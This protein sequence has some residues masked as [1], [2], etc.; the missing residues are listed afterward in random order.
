MSLDREAMRKD[1]ET[2]DVEAG[3]RAV[4]R[5]RTEHVLRQVL[6]NSGS[7]STRTAEELRA[8]G[9]VLQAHKEAHARSRGWGLEAALVAAVAI[10]VAFLHF[11]EKSSIEI[12]LRAAASDV[13]FVSKQD[14]S[15]ADGAVPINA[16]SI[17]GITSARLPPDIGSRVLRASS[18][19]ITLSVVSGTGSRLAVDPLPLKD[20]TV[21]WLTSSPPSG[22]T[23]RVIDTFAVSVSAT[24]SG[25]ILISGGQN[26]TLALRSP[27]AL[28]VSAESQ[29]SLLVNDSSLNLSRGAVP[30]ERLSFNA[31]D[32]F[33]A[34]STGRRVVAS[35]L[36]SGALRTGVLSDTSAIDLTAGLSFARSRGHLTVLK[37]DNGSIHLRFIG[38]VWNMK[39]AI[40]R[41]LMPSRLEWIRLYEQ[42]HL[43]AGTVISIMAALLLIV[44][45]LG[46]RDT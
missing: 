43:L 21:L 26:G 7:V 12:D 23:I 14:W 31:R 17:S 20:G 45:R 22:L 40:G 1:F 36:L 27:R 16:L 46:I 11:T 9:L 3:V 10:V 25:R 24:A 37:L 35:S 33:V 30:I 4:L 5:E 6:Q 42:R 39:N 13:S 38:E 34:R 32:E 19:P 15:L 44:R 41:S 2:P 18:V 28:R 8:L 29:I